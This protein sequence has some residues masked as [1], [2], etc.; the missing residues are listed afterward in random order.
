MQR[1]VESPEESAGH[2]IKRKGEGASSA[3]RKRTRTSIALLKAEPNTT[4]GSA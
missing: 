2:I 1:R 4:C 3:T